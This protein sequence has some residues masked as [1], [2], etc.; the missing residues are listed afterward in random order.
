MASNVVEVVNL[1]NS[2]GPGARSTGAAGFHGKI[3]NDDVRDSSHV[4][5]M[6]IDEDAGLHAV[7]V[8]KVLEV[9][10]EK[11]DARPVSASAAPAATPLPRTRPSKVR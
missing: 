7:V 1:Y 9:L 8:A 5:H 4:G 3:L 6:H 2:G 11:P 10:R